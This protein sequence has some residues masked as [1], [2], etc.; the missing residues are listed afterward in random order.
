MPNC[1]HPQGLS[2][3]KQNFNK[4]GQRQFAHKVYSLDG[5]EVLIGAQAAQLVVSEKNGE[6]TVS[7]V[8]LFDGGRISARK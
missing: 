6:K 8:E 2:E 7:G 5:V 1:G 4:G 3:L